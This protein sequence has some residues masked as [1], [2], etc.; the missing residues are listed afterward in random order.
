MVKQHTFNTIGVVE[1]AA[2][3]TSVP[4]TAHLISTAY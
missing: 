3:A 2:Q 4:W 1:F